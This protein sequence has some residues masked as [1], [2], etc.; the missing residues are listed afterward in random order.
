MFY[1]KFQKI[2]NLYL[3]ILNN[4]KLIGY[5]SKFK[6]KW[7]LW[8]HNFHDTNWNIDSYQK[9][10]TFN[11]IFDFWRVYNN[12][13]SLKSGMYFLMKNNINPIWED[14]NNKNGG[15]WSIKISKN[16]E[17]YWLNLSM[18]LINNDLDKNNNINGIS[19]SYKKHYYII[20][21]WINNLEKNNLDN[22]NISNNIKNNI[23]FNK[24]K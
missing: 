6:D 17:Q 5:K 11:N 9:I 8:F 1:N 18:S 21:I 19:I 23:I 4:K 16:I 20:K 14:E 7:T 13:Y 12:H 15:Y 22:I 3:I 2:V 10:Y 24:Y